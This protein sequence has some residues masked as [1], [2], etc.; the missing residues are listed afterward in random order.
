M[1]QLAHIKSARRRS[2]R[3]CSL[4]Q[5]SRIRKEFTSVNP[6]PEIFPPSLTYL[7]LSFDSK[8]RIRGSCGAD[9]V[10][11]DLGARSFY[12]QDGF[13][14][15]AEGFWRGLSRDERKMRRGYQWKS[16]T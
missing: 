13:S 11:L 4:D 12:G 2:W 6:V 9:E 15:A 16:G 14:V 10:L 1:E 8:L 3:R 7:I 5:T